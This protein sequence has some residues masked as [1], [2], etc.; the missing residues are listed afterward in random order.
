MRTRLFGLAS[1]AALAVAGPANAGGRFLVVDRMAAKGAARVVYK[2]PGPAAA[3]PMG[4]G[5]DALDLAVTV[6]IGARTTDF[7]VPAGAY[8]GVEG[9]KVNDA[10]QALF[11][12]GSAPGGTTGIGK[13]SLRA[14]SGVTLVARA[15]GDAGQPIDAAGASASAVDV[16]VAATSG[17]SDGALC[18]HFAPGDCI[19]RVLD[20]GAGTKL[21]CRNGWPDPSCVA[22]G[23]VAGDFLCTELLGFSQTLMW[24]ETPEFQLE[25]DGT[26][27][28]VRFRA[29]GDLDVWADPNADAW[30]APVV[31][32]CTGNG[33][34][35][36][37]SP[38]ALGSAAPDR[39]VL[40]ITLDHYESDVT[41]WVAKLRGAIA[42][43][44]A[45]RPQ[46]RQIVLQ[47]VVGG[48]R[49]A[50]C[51]FPGE[52]RGV[53]ASYNHPYIDAAIATVVRDAPD[54]VAGISPEVASCGAY[55]DEVGHL[56]EAGRGPVGTAVG[57]YYA[58]V[59]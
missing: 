38:C 56:T 36:L 58:L 57:R 53:R 24:E 37:C 43:I 16:R 41:V 34:P 59:P 40:T 18:M 48:P 17:A 31:T 10:E 8:D 47:P 23:G 2:A 42:T 33:S 14:A 32:G 28:Q 29:G 6:R 21:S 13:A 22:F 45:R 4:G 12:N 44:R 35:I 7:R 46:V 15:L 11:V 26:R 49:H 19:E 50:L 30:R 9:W 55:E 25:I 3:L 51:A 52:P 54:L 5:P 39:V 27:W 20:D 1:L